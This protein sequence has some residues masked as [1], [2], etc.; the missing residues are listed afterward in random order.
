MI[1]S[2]AQ[3]SYGCATWNIH[4]ARG[5]DGGVNPERIQ[6]VIATDIAAVKPD[7][8]ALQEADGE[9]PPHEGLLDP[10]Q[11]ERST[12]LRWVHQD[13]ET[14]WGAQSTGFLGNILFL[15]PGFVIRN[16]ALVDLPGHYPRGAVVVETWRDGQDLRIIATHLSLSQWLRA[17]Q[18]RT[19]GQHV[20]R[21]PAMRTLLLGDL[22][23]WR[24]WG[25][26]ALSQRF[27]G[28]FLHGG[29]VASFPAK[30][31]LLPLDRI[32]IDGAEGPTGLRAL[33]SP[34]IR[35]AS[36]HRPFTARIAAVPRDQFQARGRASSFA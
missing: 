30:R 8:L 34:Q 10:E 14:R 16:L 23:E 27:F 24:P 31:A 33:D 9:D 18:M 15:H 11:I 20:A 25:G 35:E 21:R 13:P 5:A 7:I 28:S 26:L 12:G 1:D 2:D 19:L 29:G 32:L 17:V 4:R 36:D 22:N 6:Q 3:L